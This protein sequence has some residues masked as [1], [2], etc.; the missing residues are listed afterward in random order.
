LDGRWQAQ[1]H[2]ARY[3]LKETE[4]MYNTQL[5]PREPL[6][7]RRLTDFYKKKGKKMHEHNSK[8]YDHTRKKTE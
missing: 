7:N 4:E 1:S 6:K 3:H 2:K 5:L 8:W